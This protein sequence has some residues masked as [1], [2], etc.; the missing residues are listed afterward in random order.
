MMKYSIYYIIL[1]CF[2]ANLSFAQEDP[3][4]GISQDS[5]YSLHDN[6]YSS[7]DNLDYKSA[8]EVATQIIFGV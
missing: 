5:I 6:V 7:L 3:I 4:S 8:I 1:S 2:C